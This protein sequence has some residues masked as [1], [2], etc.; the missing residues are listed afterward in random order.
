MNIEKQI[1]KT[2]I[3][4]TFY[5][6]HVGLLTIMLPATIYTYNSSNDSFDFIVVLGW[7]ILALL[8]TTTSL[9]FLKII[10]K[11]DDLIVNAGFNIY[12][13]DI[14]TINTIRLGET[15]WVGF[16]KHG[17]AKK[18][19]VISSK[20]KND[21]YITPRNEEVF[22]QKIVQINPNIIIKKADH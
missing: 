6:M 8:F 15:M 22:L 20:F 11:D 17:T 18:G 21:L 12:K 7:F 2:K 3:D 5:L 10:I 14:K 9:L 1:F 4:N 16:H 19:L 13:I